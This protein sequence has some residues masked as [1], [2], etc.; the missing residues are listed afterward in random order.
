M[1]TL[2]KKKEL[3]SKFGKNPQDTGAPE[4]QIAILSERIT[5]LTGHLGINKKDYSS[6]RGM[7]KLIGLRRRL[8]RFLSV[9]DSPRYDKI[10]KE[11]DLRK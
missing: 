5:N 11:L 8:L 9:S 6:M 3:V 2:E 4:V 1:I 7:M 10:I